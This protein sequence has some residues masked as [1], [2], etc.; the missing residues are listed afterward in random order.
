MA[1][2][3]GDVIGRAS[4]TLLDAAGTRWPFSELNGYIND[5][6]RDVL[7]LAPEA[8]SVRTVLTLAAGVKQD[9]PAG[10][11]ALLRV[12]CNV[13]GSGEPYTMGLAVT[14]IRR[15][16]LDANI[17]GWQQTAVVP[18]QAIVA[19]LVEDEVP[20]TSFQV[21]PGNTGTGKIQV[22][23][24]KR[25]A[26]IATPGSPT[27]LGS[28]TATMEIDDAYMPAITDYV[29]SKAL[30]KEVASPTA[31][32]KAQGFYARWAQVFGIKLQAEKRANPLQAAPN[33]QGTAS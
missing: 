13:T 23:A 20:Q 29:I 3:N 19:H 7:A 17:P 11:G 4:T 1:F 10:F 14:P 27:V 21:F 2:T 25:P 28:Y 33:P 26:V 8:L 15:G 9:L 31:A 22:V 12:D 18:Y 6:L 32:A 24:A 5:C 30:Q 16:V